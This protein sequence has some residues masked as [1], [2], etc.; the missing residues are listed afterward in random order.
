MTIQHSFKNP[1]LNIDANEF[2]SDD[3]IRYWAS[4]LECMN[5][6]EDNFCNNRT[7]MF[8]EGARGTGK[9][10]LLK[11]YSYDVQHLNDLQNELKY[12]GI[13]LRLND[14]KYL[15][16]NNKRISSEISKS[17][18]INYLELSMLYK[19][20]S[21]FLLMMDKKLICFNTETAFCEKMT[22]LLKREATVD[23]AKNF[24]ELLNHIKL[25]I[26]DLDK[27]RSEISFNNIVPS[28]REYDIGELC[29]NSLEQLV[30]LNKNLKEYA[31]VIM[32][33]EYEN[34]N[35]SQQTIVNTLIK[36][37]GTYNNGCAITFR[38]GHRPNGIYSYQTEANNEFLQQGKDYIKIEIS[39]V[40]KNKI[41]EKFL[42]EIAKK[43]ISDSGCFLSDNICKYLM[44]SEIMFGKQ[45][46]WSTV[47]KDI[48]NLFQIKLLNLLRAIL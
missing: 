33:D 8:I 18:F 46:I 36:M 22:Q 19:I 42:L 10:M 3:V 38:I 13:Y 26:Y 16:S 11:Y 39:N 23:I 47:K 28:F 25:L 4:P 6:T 31:F 35:E 12:I 48:L 29:F 32:I 40:K 37:A 45:G 44:S 9:T 21:T 15:S 5:I 14:L 41:F 24:N 27:Y 34:Y 2:T 43:R 20:I 7:P 30:T 17:L 1:F